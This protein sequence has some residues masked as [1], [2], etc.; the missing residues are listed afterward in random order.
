MLD[1]G[2][3]PDPPDRP[4]MWSVF[5]CTRGFKQ[6]KQKVAA[7]SARAERATLLCR[8]FPDMRTNL[9]NVANVLRAGGKAFYVVDD[10]K[11]RVSKA[12]CY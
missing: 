2:S 8:Y 7:G 5:L 6:L 3:N 9:A 4:L 10:S 11:T 12:Q 1:A